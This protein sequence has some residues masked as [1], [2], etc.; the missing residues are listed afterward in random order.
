MWNL[1]APTDFRGFRVDLPMTCYEPLL[2]HWRQEG[3][4]YAVTFRLGD[5]LPQS[6]LRELREFKAE[7]KRRFPP[8]RS[9]A[10]RDA[11]SQAAMQRIET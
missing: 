2:P 7:W 1:P 8:P 3:A 6:K 11:M 9:T 10:D 4:I 5:S